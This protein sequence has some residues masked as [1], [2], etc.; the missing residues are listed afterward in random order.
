VT[1]VRRADANTILTAVSRIVWNTIY[2]EF[3]FDFNL[4]V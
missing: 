1:I 2:H 4:R 3:I